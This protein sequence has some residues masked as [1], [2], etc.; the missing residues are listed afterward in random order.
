MDGSK[1]QSLASAGCDGGE[2]ALN[3]KLRS[4]LILKIADKDKEVL[5]SL[6]FAATPT[7]CYS[8]CG[9]VRLTRPEVSHTKVTLATQKK[10]YCEVRPS[11]LTRMFNFSPRCFGACHC[12]HYCCMS[13]L[14]K[15][16]NI[17]AKTISFFFFFFGWE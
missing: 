8:L 6:L 11:I 13:A 3:L 14:D 12:C 16:E 9:V 2:L 17:L 15:N 4:C 1:Q 5:H 7:N 10:N